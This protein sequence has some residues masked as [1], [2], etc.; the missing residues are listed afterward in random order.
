MMDGNNGGWKGWWMETM[1]RNN[2]GWKIIKIETIVNGYGC[3]M[4]TDGND[5]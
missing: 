5:G 4:I 1:D 3:E 2:G